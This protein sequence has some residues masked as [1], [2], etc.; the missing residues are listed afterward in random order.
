M[1]GTLPVIYINTENSAPVVDKEL[2]I[3]AFLY[4]TVPDDCPLNVTGSETEPVAL[5]IKGRGNASWKLPQKPYKIKF[6]TSQDLLGMPGHKHYALI[7]FASGYAGWL[8]GNIGM[9]IARATD[10][11]WA[12]RT[13][14]C[15]LVLNGSYEGL[16]FV[17]ESMKIGANR[18]NIFEQPD[19]NEDPGTI[20]GGWLVEIDNY[21]DPCQISIQE[22]EN[23]MMLIT[24]KTPEELSAMQEEW[25]TAQFNSMNNAIYS[26]D[27]S[28]NGWA[29]YIDPESV[30][31][32]FIVRELLH[33][34]DGYNGSFYLHKDLEQKW[35][36]GPMWDLAFGGT[37]NDWIMNDHPSYSAVHWIEPI[38]NTDAFRNALKKQWEIFAP[39]LESIIEAAT[40]LA[41]RCAAADA[42]NAQRWPEGPD[43]NTAGKLQ[44]FVNGLQANA[45]W[46]S[47]NMPQINSGAASIT[48]AGPGESHFFRLDGTPADC[49]NLG[50]GIYIRINGCKAD[51]VVINR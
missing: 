30:A 14:A 46:I 36:F 9:E 31:R 24:Y 41:N 47:D 17:V 8:A 1:T 35:N 48:V 44:Y 23:M 13:E 12:P 25:L 29:E 26:G 20:D 21:T 27:A 4:T 33:D 34:T 45:Q 19:L 40:E 42:L 7:P 18:L 37:K 11:S 51:K 50:N 43:G 49:R 10:Q 16:Y 38:F 28:G 15:E 2:K 32:Y 5:T 3:D 22:T 6:E 39:R